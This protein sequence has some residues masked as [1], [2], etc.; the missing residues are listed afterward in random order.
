[1]TAMFEFLTPQIFNMLVIA[2]LL[3][4]LALIAYRFTRDMQRPLPP[5]QREQAHD[6]ISS[7]SYDDTDSSQSAPINDDVSAQKRQKS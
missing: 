3:V 2:N 4:G 5:Q 6:E 1:M 7:F